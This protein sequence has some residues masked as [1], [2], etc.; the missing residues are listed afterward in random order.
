MNTKL[1][2]I[3]NQ[4]TACTLT[5]EE[6]EK[7]L[8]ECLGLVTPVAVLTTPCRL[9]QAAR[10]QITKDWHTVFEGRSK[11]VIL[12][13]GLT[14]ANRYEYMPESLKAKV[15]DIEVVTTE[16]GFDMRINGD[17]MPPMTRMEMVFVP[18]ELPKVRCDFIAMPARTGK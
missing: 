4:Y 10:E 11:A 13:E 16:A 1:Q 15:G 14:L 6:A 17:R 7:E 3:L 12:Q 9:S 8:R 5:L 2:S 18:G